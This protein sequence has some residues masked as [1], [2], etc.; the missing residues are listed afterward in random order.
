M[1]GLKR[2]VGYRVAA[3]AVV[4]ACLS[5]SSSAVS[6]VETLRPAFAPS[7]NIGWIADSNLFTPPASGPGPVMS[8]PAHPRISNAQ[9][10]TSGR[11][12]SFPVAD[13]NSP[14]LQ[15]W[16]KEAV[17][18][19]NSA[20]LSGKPGYPRSVSCWPMGVPGV[21]LNIVQPV[22]FLQTPKEIVLLWQMDR[23]VRHIYINVPHSTRPKPSWFGESVGHYEEDTLVVDTIGLNDK[24][25]VDDFRTPHTEKLHVIER[26]RMIEGGKTLEVNVHVEDPGAFTAPWNAAQRYR[27][28]EDSA[29]VERVCAENPTNYFSLDMEPV[30]SADKPDF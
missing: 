11:P 15:P 4:V 25:F 24:S 12:P 16:A 29:L 26:F 3:N 6:A 5:I 22:Y 17:Q 30:P 10:A 27:R 14:I 20:I 18:K 21:L 1:Q 23:G 2:R 13:V 19:R 9:A 7:A 28:V 8:D